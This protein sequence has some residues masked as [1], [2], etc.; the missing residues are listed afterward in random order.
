MMSSQ[1]TGPARVIHTG[2]V[3]VDVTMRVAA[4][5]S[6]G[7]EVFAD[8]FSLQVGGGFN[9]LHSIRQA[10][11]EA[12][13]LGPVGDGVLGRAVIEALDR[14]G[15]EFAGATVEGLDTGICVALTD[16]TAERT[17][18]STMGAECRVP[19]DAFDHVE[20]GEGD[21]LYVS[22]YSLIDDSNRAA[23]ERLAGS[24]VAGGGVGR[25]DEGGGEPEPTDTHPHSTR[26]RALIDTSPMIGDVPVDVLETMNG[27]HPIWSANERET[28]IL[29]DLFG[30]P[31][32]AEI[33]ALCSSLSRRLRTTVI[34]RVGASGA[35][36]SRDGS[37]AELVPSIPVTPVDT[38]G[39]GDAHSGVLCALLAEGMDFERALR[40][41]NVAA[42]L[43]TT[44]P[45]PATCPART[46]FLSR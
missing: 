20:L 13:Y 30:I 21:M 28:R 44:V 14:D 27:F 43:S 42:A 35:W 22:G 34:A 26:P 37:P 9:V 41:A 4:V 2:Q 24:W 19:L 6:P 32:D 15:V 16:D 23:L 40:V 3:V 46:E 17:F 36:W 12:V 10:G 25:V 45:G 29:A 8:S 33:P 5:P 1:G 18:L 38:N 39:A 31:A 11:A 7:A